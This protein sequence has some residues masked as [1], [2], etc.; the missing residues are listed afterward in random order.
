MNQRIAEMAAWSR[1]HDI[2]PQPVKTEYDPRD[3]LYPEPV[4]IARRL[5]K[6][7]LN[8]EVQLTPHDRMTGVLTF[9]GSVPAD[10]FHRTGHRHFSEILE[11]FYCKPQENL[12]TFEWQ[13]SVAEFGRM[14]REGVDG[15]R[16]RIAASRKEHAGDQDALDF[17]DGCE[18]ICEAIEKWGDKCARKCE[19]TAAAEADPERREELLKMA[20]ICRRVPAHPARTFRE[21]VQ[22]VYACFNYQPDSLGTVDRYLLKL[23]RQDIASGE[24]T[25]EEAKEY[26]QELFIMVDG[27]T[28]FN[29]GGNRCNYGG[30]SHFAIGGYTLD[31][32]DGYTEL[33]ELIL[34]ALM[35]LPTYRPQ[36]SF[37]WTKKTPYE[38]LWHVLD[39]ERKDASKRICIISDEPRIEALMRNGGIRY[40]DAVNYST[41][42]CNEPALQG[43]I[44][45]GGNMF[46]IARSLTRTLHEYSD[47]C[48]A[49]ADFDVFYALYERELTRDMERC[50][51]YADRFNKARARD[52]NVLS[53]MFLRGCIENARSVTQGGCSLAVGGDGVM[54]LVC[55]IDSLTVI[56]QFVYDEKSVTMAEMIQ[57]LKDDWKGHELL[58]ARI[59]KTAKFFGNDEEISNEMAARISHS[60]CLLAHA[61]PGTFHSPVLFGS[62]AGYN[63][64][65]A[66]FG[67]QT[68]A[69]PD[70]RFSGDAFMVGMGQT[71]GKDRQ[72]MTALL[73]SVAKGD[74]HGIFAGPYVCNMNVDPALIV[75]DEQFDKT[76]HMIEAYLKKGGLHLQLNYVKPED[77]KR[78]KVHPEEYKSL[79][80][81]VSGFSANFVILPEDIQDDVIR[82]TLVR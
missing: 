51:W 37:R 30:E 39:C 38:V 16:A 62:Q 74:P 28:P 33:T 60:M 70:G 55:V 64:H 24:M 56:K 46:N 6:Y 10:L 82:R 54:G 2:R 57:A 43:G 4:M 29:A 42:G 20:R 61:N 21:G 25:R 35:E 1:N 65:Y 71:A 68:P 66:W 73:N 40:E 45:Y 41:C 58:H 3:I 44:W 12:C 69:T 77:L 32:E 48:C 5:K 72:G 17:L 27:H 59:L 50:T 53:S 80:V 76:V 11:V 13:H 9:D 78:A 7:I 47:E 63:P 22:S 81:R 23:Y 19:E 79:R 52:I 67:R 75:N 15:F 18:I 26:L 49:C 36:I 8:Q 31:G 34:E 14:V